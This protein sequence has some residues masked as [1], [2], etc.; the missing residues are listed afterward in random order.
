VHDGPDRRSDSHGVSESG[1]GERRLHA[2]IDRV[3]DDP[4][5][6]GVL[7]GADVELAL[8]GAVFGDVG[9]PELVGTRSA[10]LASDEIIEYIELL[11]EASLNESVVDEEPWPEPPLAADEPRRSFRGFS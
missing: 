1:H 10:E 8:I 11:D 7:D 5:R 9:E 2:L 3:T 6:P 4:V